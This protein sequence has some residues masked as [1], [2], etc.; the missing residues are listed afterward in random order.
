MKKQP[1]IPANFEIPQLLETPK[2]RLRMLTVNDLVKDFDAVVSSSQHLLATK[3]FGPR[4]T[5]PKNISLEQNLIDI[6][7]HQKEFQKRSSFAYTV[8]NLD[9]SQCLGCMYIYPSNNP[10]YQ[11]MVVMWVRESEK[12]TALDTHLFESVQQWINDQW[13]FDTVAY[14][15]RSISWKEWEV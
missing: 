4:Q 14:P 15:G 3:P 7:W 11:A 8:M 6:G 5:W 9:E 13:C 12:N 1:F 2:M 10:Q